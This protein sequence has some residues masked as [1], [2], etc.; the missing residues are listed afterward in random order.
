MPRA[1]RLAVAT[2]PDVTAVRVDVTAV[3]EIPS[4]FLRNAVARVAPGITSL[5]CA[6]SQSRSALLTRMSIKVSQFKWFKEVL[7]VG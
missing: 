6:T 3:L 4:L 7:G 2:R 5:P 1:A